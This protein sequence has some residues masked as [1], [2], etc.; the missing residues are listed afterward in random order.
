MMVVMKDV[1]DDLGVVDTLP[2]GNLSRRT[3]RAASQESYGIR[4]LR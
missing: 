4:R 3:S 2:I 1:L